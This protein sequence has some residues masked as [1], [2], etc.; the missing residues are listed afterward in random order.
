M[1]VSVIPVRIFLL[2]TKDL[3]IVYSFQIDY[4]WFTWL[5]LCI[6]LFGPCWIKERG[7]VILRFYSFSGGV[8]WRKGNFCRVLVSQIR[9]I[10]Q[11][12]AD[13]NRCWLVSILASSTL[14]L[15]FGGYFKEISIISIKLK[16]HNL[17]F[18]SSKENAFNSHALL[19]WWLKHCYI[20]CL[21]WFVE[22]FVFS[23]FD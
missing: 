17:L 16:L 20:S 15:N 6:T 5:A 13:K 3:K 10:V 9:W 11:Y 1:I 23:R 7:E 18:C 21:V 4:L 12:E 8:D 2:K 22:S 19:C 14:C